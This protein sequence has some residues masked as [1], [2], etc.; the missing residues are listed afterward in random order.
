[1]QSSRKDDVV[2]GSIPGSKITLTVDATTGQIQSTV[3]WTEAPHDVHI[4]L[5]CSAHK[6]G[7][8]VDTM[9]GLGDRVS[10]HGGGRLSLKPVDSAKEAWRERGFSA[11]AISGTWEK[12]VPPKPRAPLLPTRPP[13]AL[14]PTRPPPTPQH[15]AL[16]PAG[17]PPM[18]PPSPTTRGASPQPPDPLRGHLEATRSVAEVEA[19]RATA[20][21]GGSAAI[22]AAASAGSDSADVIVQQLRMAR[23]LSED[24]CGNQ[25]LLEQVAEMG[26][27]AG[28]NPRFRGKG[29]LVEGGVDLLMIETVFDT[30]NCKAAILAVDQYFIESKKER[31][32]VMLGATV[33]DNSGRTLSGQTIEAVYVSVKRAQ[34]FTVGINCAHCA[35]GAAQMKGSYKKLCDMN[36]AWCHVCP[37]AGL[38]NAMGGYDEDPEIFFSN[39]LD[40]AKDLILNF[41]G[42]RCGTFPSQIAAV[43]KKVKDCPVRKLPELPK[44]PSMMLS[45]LE[46]CHVT[47]EAGF[48]WVGHGMEVCIAQCEKKAD[49]LDFNFDSDLIDGQSAISKFMRPGI[50]E[51]TVAKLPFMIDSSKWPVVEEGLKCLQGKCVVNSISLKVVE[52]EF[53]RQAKLCMRYGAAVVIMA[54]DEKGLAATFEDKVRICQHSYKCLRENIDFPREDI[55]FDCNVLTI[56]KRTCPCVSFS[57]GLSNLSFSFRG[58]NSLRDAMHSVYEAIEPKTREEVIL[59]K[60]ADGNHVELFLEYAEQVR[61]PPAPAPAGPVLKIEKSAAAA[62]HFPQIFSSL[63]ETVTCEAE[64]V[65]P[66]AGCKVVDPCR[67]ESPQETQKVAEKIECKTPTPTE[68]INYFNGELKKCI[69]FLDGGMGTRIQAEN[70]EE[71]DYREDQF[72]DFSEKDIHKEYF[73]AGSD[74]CETNTFNGTTISEGEYKMQAVV[75]E[76]N[77]VGA[78][79]AKKAA[80]EVTKEERHKPRFVAGA[81]GPTGRT[82]SESPSVE[83]PSF[84]SVIW[85]ELVESYKQQAAILAVD[86]YFIESKKAVYVSVKHAQPFTVGINCALGAAQMKGSYK[87]L[88]DMNSAWCHVCPSA[89]LPNAMG[90]YDEDPEIFFSNILDY[91]KDLILR[92][93]PFPDRFQWVGERCNLMGSA[94]FKKLVDAYKWDEAKLP[95]MIDSSKWPVVEESLQCVQ[96]KCVVNSI[97]LKVCEEEFLRQAKLCMRY[98]AAVVITA[99]DE[100]GQAATFEFK[101][102][103]C[104]RSYKCLREN[105]D[106]PREDIIFDCNVLT[107]NKR[108]CPCVSFSG[109]LSNLS[110]SFPGLNSLRDAM[111]SVYEDIE[112]KTREEVILNKSADGNHVEL[113]L[114][115]AEQVRKPPAPAPAGPVLKIEKSAAAAEHF[116]QIFSSLKETVT[117]EAEHVQPKAGCKVVDP[118]RV[119]SPQETQKVAQ[120]I[121]CKTPTPTEV[122]KYFNGEL[123]KCIC[124]LDGGMGT[125]I[126]AENLEEA[127]YREDQ[128]KDFSEK[129]IHKEYFL[130]GSD[131]CETNTFNGTTISQGEYK[132]QA[133]VHEMN[134][135]GAQ[136]AKKAA[137]EVTKEERHKPRFVAGAVGPTGRTL[138]ES[139]SVEDP[140]FRSVIWD[141]LVEPYKQ[142]AAILAVDQ[143]FIESKKAVYVSVK[144]AQPFTVGINCALGAAQMKGSYKKLCD[145]NSAWC[146]VCPS[147]GL[148]NATGGYDEDPEIFFSNILDCP[149]RKL[150]ELPKYPSVMLS[151]LE[152]CHVTAEAGFQWVGERCNLMGSAKFKKL[153]DAYK[154]DEA[155]AW[156]F[157]SAS[158]AEEGLQCVQGK[159][160]V[161]SISLKVCEE[162]FLRQ[163]MLC[164]RYGAAVVITAF[165]EKG[166]A[167]TFEDKVRICQRSYK[168]L[169]ENIDFPREDIIFDCNVLT[170][171]KRTCPCVSFSGGLSNLSFS[172][173]GLNSLRDAMHSVPGQSTERSLE[174]PLPQTDMEENTRK[175]AEEVILNQP[176]DGTHA[177][178]LDTS[179][180]SCGIC[181]SERAVLLSWSLCLQVERFLEHAEADSVLSVSKGIKGPKISH[182]TERNFAPEA[183]RKPAPT[184]GA[185]AGGAP[186]KAGFTSLKSPRSQPEAKDA[187]RN[188]RNGTFTERLHCGQRPWPRCYVPVPHKHDSCGIVPE[189]LINGIDK[190]IEGDTEE[191]RA[192]LQVPLRVIE[193]PLMEGLWLCFTLNI[194]SLCTLQVIRSARVMKKAKWPEIDIEKVDVIGLSG[195]EQM[196]ARGMK[197]PLMIG[198]ATTTN[199]HTAVKITAKYNNG[200]IHV[201]TSGH[202]RYVQGM[203]ASQTVC[204]TVVFA[205]LLLWLTRSV[206]KQTYKEEYAEIRV[207]YYA[208]LID[209]KWK[210]LKEA[211]SK[212]PQLGKHRSLKLVRIPSG[213]RDRFRRASLGGHPVDEVPVLIFHWGLPEITSAST[214][215]HFFERRVQQLAVGMVPSKWRRKAASLKL[216]DEKLSLT[217]NSSVSA[218]VFVHPAKYF[219]VGQVSVDQV[220]PGPQSYSERRGEAGVEGTE[221]WLGSTVLGYE[222]RKRE[223]ACRCQQGGRQSTV[224]TWANSST[225]AN[226]KELL[227]EAELS[228]TRMWARKCYWEL[229]SEPDPPVIQQG[230]SLR[231][232]ARSS[233]PINNNLKLFTAELVSC[234]GAHGR[235]RVIGKTER[236]QSSHG[237]LNDLNPPTNKRIVCASNVISRASGCNDLN[238]NDDYVKDVVGGSIPGSKITLTV[239]ATTGQIQSTVVWT[240]APHDV[241]IHLACSAHKLGLAV[242]TMAGLGDRVSRH[243]GGR[244]SLKPVDSAKEA[245]RERGFSASAISGTWEKLADVIV[246]QLRMARSLSE[247]VC[248]NQALLEQVA[249]IGSMAGVNPRFRGKGDL[250]EGGVDLLMIETV[251]DTQNCKAAILAVDQYFIESKKERLRVMLSATVVDN[252]GRTLSGQTIEAVYV[253]VKRAQPFT[254]GINCAHCALGAAQ[255]KG[256]YKKLCDM[257][258]AWCH[259]CPRAGLPNAMGGYDEDP[260]IFFSNILDYAKDLILNFVGGCCGTF[261][262]QIAAVRKKVKDCPVRKLP[263]LP[264]YPSM[265]LSGLEPCHV[266][267]EAGF[268]WVG[269]G[270]EVC[271]AQCEKKADILDFNFDSDLIDGQSAISKFMRP[272][273]TEP[274]VAKL[275][276]MIDSSKWP[277]VE[278][279]L[280]CF[281]GKCVVNSISLKVVEE[282]FLRQAK[283]CMRYGAAVVIMAF[284]EKGLAATFEDKVRICQHSY[285]CLREN[286]DFPREDIIFDCNVLTINKRTCP[287]VSFSGGLSNLSFSFRGLNSLRDAMHSV[288]EDIE[289]KTREEVILNK[290][291]DGNHVELFLEYAE[292]VRKPPAPAPAGPVLKIE[293]SA[294]A[295][296]HFPQ[297]FSSLKETVTCEAEHVQ[298][299][300]GCKVVDPCRVESPQETQKVAEKIECKTPT[301]TEVINYFNGELKKCICFLDGGMGTRIQ[302]ENLEEADYREDQFKDFSEKDANGIPFSLKGNND[303]LIFS[304]PDMIKD[305]HKEYFLAGSDICETNTFNGTTISQGEYKMQAV[306]HEMNKVGAQL[307]KKAAAEVTKEERHKPR[308]VAGAVGPTGRTL[309]ESP[310]VEDPSFRSV[311]WDELVESYKQ[312][313][314]ILAVDQ[315]FIESKK[316][317]YVSVKH[318]QP[319]T[320]GINCALG[321]AQMKGS[322]K[323]LCD[324]NS[325]W[326]H[327]CPRA[328][329]PNAM[330]GY[331]EDPEIFFSNILDYAKDLILNFV[332]GRCGTFPS[333]IAAVLQVGEGRLP[334]GRRAMQPDGLGS[335]MWPVVE[336]SLQC[337]QGKCV[338][339]SISLK[340]CEEEF[341]RQAKLC[342]RYGAAVVIT[343][344]DEKGQAAT[345]EDK[346]RI[347]QR[348]YKCL[349]ENIDFPR[350]DIIFDCNVLTINKRTCPCVSFSG[351]LSNLSFSFRGLNSLRDA[352]HSV[353]EDIE[354][355]TREEV[356]LNKSADGNHVELFL[357]YAEQVRKPP[358]PAPAGPVLKIE[359]S[360]AAAEHFPQ[361][362]SSLKETVTC[363]AEHVQPKAGCKVVDPCRVESPQETQKVAQKIECK[364][365]T[366]TE[367]I[368]YFNGELKKCI[369]FLDGGMGTRI[370]AENLE[371]ADYREDQ[372]KDFSE[373]D[374]NGIPFSLKGNNDRL[375]F[376]KPD[377]IKDIHK[378]Y[379]LAGSDICETNTFN[380]TTISQGEYKMQAVVHE[381]NKVGAQLAKKA[382]AEVTKEERHKP[383]FVAGAVGPTSRTLSESPS[384]EDPSFRSVIWD[385]LVE[386]YKQQAAILAVD[387]YFIESKKA[388]Y[389]SVKH[390]QPF[391]VG[392]NCALG[393]A[394]MKGSYKKLC[395]MNS[396]WCHV[397]PSAGLPNATGGY[398]EDPEIFFSNILDC[399]VRKLP[400]LPKY[401]SMML[402]GLEPCHVTAEAG[403]Q[404]VGERC[405]LMGS[406]KFKKLV[407]AYK[408][409][410]AMAW[411][412]ASAKLPFMIDSSEW[413]VVEEGLQ[414]V[415]GKCVVN[416]ISL[417]VCEEEFLRQAMLCMRY[418]AA[419]VITAFDEKGQ[420]ATFEDKVRICQRSYK[421]LRENIDF[422]REDIIFDCNVLTINKRTCP[423][424]SFSGGLSNLSFSFRG[425]N[426]LRDAMHSVPGQSTERSLE[427]PLPQT[428][429]EENTRKLAEE[430]ILNQPADGTHVERFLEH[431]EAV[432]KPAPTAGAAAGGAPAKDAWRNGR[433][434]TFTERL[435]CG[436]IN[437]IDKFIEGDTEEAR[438][439]L[440]VPLRVIE[441]PLMEGAFFHLFSRPSRQVIRSARVMKKAV[442]AEAR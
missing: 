132:M 271:I 317:V 367:V 355:K 155:M 120:K 42:G 394:Q 63:K 191:A 362:F 143:Y 188:G 345:F 55:I 93:L 20:G 438:A 396:A 171:N 54:F 86:Q 327:V 441:G 33:V 359:K 103:I 256:S 354:P 199:R 81:V 419:V 44:Y 209:K 56:N 418:G 27:M 14:L 300:A 213:S 200:V 24:V 167:A 437:G 276:F 37:R 366:P 50:T 228:T 349:R 340:V 45:G 431:A 118:C 381:M 137:A 306:V 78:Q 279:G 58:L 397:C 375:I 29:D 51:P 430:V 18:A 133:V 335:S 166:Q 180:P 307:A 189:R 32:R 150:P 74:I 95:F 182:K 344:F 144:H 347:C 201:D 96:G 122:I 299:K 269:H 206:D 301:P 67:V 402:S 28:V 337:V 383:R 392:I 75:H 177:G 73:L 295:A 9:A 260:E 334:V 384:V 98:G 34:P 240:E 221:R 425:L 357:E 40:Y 309:S 186:A 4:H 135:V 433:N 370:Q 247:D 339:N 7:L 154:W 196:K 159:C 360:A 17:P 386:P 156:R 435:H 412:F 26:S 195:P 374:A 328:G 291:A 326:C 393:A 232:Q 148:P 62:E 192:E 401:P 318:A 126:Q 57:G 351:G 252:S 223:K 302:A 255:M 3:V 284:D 341:L 436:L 343:A 107:I 432:R 248:G 128:F 142:Q 127:D 282:E 283:L 336:E 89:G 185:A 15:S 123:K 377:M 310:S 304:K 139:P 157:A 41:V 259:V 153:V 423:C 289:P 160:V 408:W 115:Y 224:R 92:H 387:Q 77:K 66:K 131:I 288:Y 82:L 254:V 130:A 293:K 99:F 70:L 90:G 305:I 216:T 258:S 68:V 245:W 404:W 114:E 403:F 239:D 292:Q 152:P 181:G 371:E 321:A 197:A 208:T 338:V 39:I 250:V 225:D 203:S 43:R 312:Q 76:M 222:K 140:S 242:D 217:A 174:G 178:S 145:M 353:Y 218:L 202:S 329:L 263:E 308:F 273:I 390:A 88:C 414:C 264:K 251:F 85:D 234:G 287:C 331:D 48:Q 134:K 405:N 117:C 1:M 346:V 83:D 411:R 183:V 172:F 294:A 391:T 268:Q 296:E 227:G 332:G 274:T 272:G 231:H 324:M 173:R 210:S 368:N 110:F 398:D 372:F 80:G 6:L 407:D 358:A 244:L 426:S 406:A 129:D 439:E 46:P 168:C 113:F 13:S 364:T 280:K 416:S 187:W 303:R 277:V 278:E 369:C 243:G 79:L 158:Q 428:D 170:I 350:E 109:G 193:G 420:A 108:T 316:A 198:G 147:A 365:P 106:F 121:E 395:D 421:C 220:Q 212:K 257:N 429:M 5:A 116:P 236:A 286:I 204:L 100:K 363:E 323:K 230:R 205:N 262:S 440:Q 175:L 19:F 313:A 434:G 59:N 229:N 104:Q 38:P 151:G 25:A 125:R 10:R 261:P 22:P 36:S 21:T 119:E 176:A 179:L 211:Q 333:Q 146:H 31:L 267:A 376:S 190:F 65:Q 165:D 184:A 270:M 314:A 61:K 297:I 238:L 141:E 47:A 413:P 352:M 219:S 298:P 87:K 322:Y 149:V 241:H 53:L 417:K 215:A 382:A 356:I 400:E 11:S 410:E 427:G 169:R 2:G 361:I 389:V 138:S 330:G 379:F 342:M 23:S 102:R 281:Q 52:E 101:V 325:A 194:A 207:E 71:A 424:V 72:K 237:S 422:P 275:P 124:F 320:V 380:G 385:E 60:S 161:N 105:I 84:R 415:Q 163:A 311:I 290:S 69:C 249:E 265:M 16:P 162:E 97:S 112:P 91:A 94:K 388:V 49:I 164:M 233:K 30:Q 266:T 235:S 373:K 253:S 399:P 226:F 214:R 111:H 64:H 12:L 348:S 319:F 442:R 8:A 136:L 409:D 285:K 246:Q 378:E 35:L 315:Y